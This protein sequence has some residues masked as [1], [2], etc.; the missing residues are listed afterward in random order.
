MS[1]PSS[2]WNQ[3]ELCIY[4]AKNLERGYMY[5]SVVQILFLWNIYI[6]PH[7][8][9][10]FL[11]SV[12]FPAVWSGVQRRDVA[13]CDKK[14]HPEWSFHY[15]HCSASAHP[16]LS[17]LHHWVPLLERWLHH[18]GWQVENQDPWCRYCFFILKFA[19][20][21]YILCLPNLIFV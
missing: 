12:L 11:Y 21:I 3:C 14:C 8:Y 17:L 2:H 6:L 19:P 1:M 15:P 4:E 9:S 10:F 18:G 5:V 7:L 16:S 13:K 20:N